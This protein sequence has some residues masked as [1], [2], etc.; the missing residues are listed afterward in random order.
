MSAPVDGVVVLAPR[1]PV[2]GV[3]ELVELETLEDVDVDGPV[4][5]VVSDV[6]VDGSVTTVVRDVD[7]VGSV[8]TVLSD[9][10]W[11]LVECE[12]DVSLLVGVDSVVSADDVV[13]L[14]DELELDVDDDELVVSELDLVLFVE[15][16]VVL[17]VEV[18]V[19]ELL[20]MVLCV[21]LDE[22]V[23]WFVDDVV[24][25]LVVEDVDVELSPAH[26]LDSVKSP[27]PSESSVPVPS[28]SVV[29]SV[30]ADSGTHAQSRV[31]PPSASTTTALYP[32]SFC[33][34]TY[35]TVNSVLPPPKLALNPVPL[36]SKPSLAG[37]T[38]CQ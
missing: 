31:T 32:P 37:M 3:D 20:L 24:L 30:I 6:D 33:C 10:D 36:N 1:T 18:E 23:V 14:V 38:K 27:L 29:S 5:A 2:D 15:L 4:T 28:A 9:V 34:W 21:L 16:D 12:D 7:V 26:V 13:L 8:T 11:L 35:V 25:E 17:F 19:S 22:D